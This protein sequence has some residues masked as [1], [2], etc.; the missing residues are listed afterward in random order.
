MYKELISVVEHSLDNNFA[1]L[2][3]ARMEKHERTDDSV[4]EV[5]DV[6]VESDDS[7]EEVEN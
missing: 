1:D 3:I 6:V 2:Y 5:D 4:E 7:V